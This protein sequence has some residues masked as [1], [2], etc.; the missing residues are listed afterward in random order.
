[1]MRE[2][3]AVAIA[4]VTIAR[5][6]AGIGAMSAAVPDWPEPS[7]RRARNAAVITAPSAA[8]IGAKTAAFGK[9]LSVRGKERASAPLAVVTTAR[10][11]VGGDA[12]NAARKALPSRARWDAGRAGATKIRRRPVVSAAP[13]APESG[14]SGAAAATAGV[15]AANEGTAGLR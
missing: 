9:L 12:R 4:V 11:A 2:L 5:S 13:I 10:R 7:L 1:M 8:E 15:V 14:A 6:V 3:R